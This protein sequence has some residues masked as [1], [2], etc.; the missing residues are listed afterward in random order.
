M[1]TK[2]SV[3]T[4][5]FNKKFR[6]GLSSQS[7]FAFCDLESGFRV[8][9]VPEQFVN[10]LLKIYNKNRFLTGMLQTLHLDE[11]SLKMEGFKF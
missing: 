9:K 10:F 7:F 5:F 4:G 11:K 6:L 2:F 8:L 3:Y 1:R